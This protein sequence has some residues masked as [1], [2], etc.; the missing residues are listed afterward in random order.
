M[1][2]SLRSLA[3]EIEDA[4]AAAYRYLW[5]CTTSTRVR[6]RARAHVCVCEYVS[7]RPVW[8]ARRGD[9]ATR[10]RDHRGPSSACL[11]SVFGLSIGKLRCSR[12]LKSM[13]TFLPPF[14][15]VLVCSAFA[16]RVSLIPSIWPARRHSATIRIRG[17]F[18]AR[19]NRQLLEL[20]GFFSQRWP[21]EEKQFRCNRKC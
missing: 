4:Y 10:R 20:P 8:R 11:Y 9:A 12:P 13:N 17:A 18:R 3:K 16:D 21:I 6:V 7:L 5:M 19:R 1:Q 2:I 14:L 15:I